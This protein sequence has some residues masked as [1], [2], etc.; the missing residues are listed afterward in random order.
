MLLTKTE[1]TR[2]GAKVLLIRRPHQLRLVRCKPTGPR[3]QPDEHK[4]RRNRYRTRQPCL[5]EPRENQRDCQA[6]DTLAEL[7]DSGLVQT[8]HFN[9]KEG[10]TALG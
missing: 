9:R 2:G 10:A 6:G 4:W 8:F 5:T 3:Y 1:R 7:R